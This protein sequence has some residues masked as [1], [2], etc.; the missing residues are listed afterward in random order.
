LDLTKLACTGA[1]SEF[2]LLNPGNNNVPPEPELGNGSSANAVYDASKPD[3][4]TLSVGADDLH[5]GDAVKNCYESL[6]DCHPDPTN[7]LVAQKANLIR[8][9]TEIKQRGEAAGKVPLVLLTTYYDPFPAQ[10]PAQP[11]DCVDLAPFHILFTSKGLL[12]NYEMDVLRNDLLFL[13]HNIRSAA[14]DFPNVLVV[15]PPPAFQQHTWCSS[16]PWVYGPS[17]DAPSLAH[18]TGWNNPAPFHP[19]PEGQAAIA[20][21]LESAI[22]NAQVVPTGEDINVPVGSGASVTF[23]QVTSSGSVVLAPEGSG[24]T[25]PPSDNHVRQ[26]AFDIATSAGYQGNIRISVPSS[27]PAELYHYTNGAWQQV[28]DST[29]DGHN[30]TGSVTSLSPFA[31]GTPA[32]QVHASFTETGAGEAPASVSFDASGSSV[33]SGGTIAGYQWDFGDGTADT[34]KTPTHQYTRSGS[35]HVVL[36]AT[37]DQ[38]AVATASGIVVIT[39]SPPTAAISAPAQAAPSQVISF[40][41]AES[42]DP[43]GSISDWVWDFGDGSGTQTGT[44]VQHSYETPGTYTVTLIALDDEGAAGSATTQ[45]QVLAPLATPPSDA[46]PPETRITSGPAHRSKKRKLRFRFTANEAGSAFRCK[47]DHHAFAPCVS[48]RTYRVKPGVHLFQVYAI[49]AAGNRDTTPAR[50]KIKVTK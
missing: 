3:I 43:N 37:S 24:P 45:V 30:V 28:A 44:E 38:G 10:Y 25:L 18:P 13:N 42:S 15:N 41:G 49:D 7:D 5:F 11:S 22:S 46:V 32:P 2:G 47:L 19:T 35:Y 8:V 27:Q 36:R 20:N 34:G 9:L 29:F 1:S 33:D 21:E 12:S 50:W 17:I 39:N 26:S 48:P 40:S 6:S 14:A 31:L 16:D 23:D 4:V